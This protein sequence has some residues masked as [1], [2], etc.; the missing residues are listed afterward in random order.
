MADKYTEPRPTPRQGDASM[1]ALY[2]KAPPTFREL[3]A[4]AIDA[5]SNAGAA[6][7]GFGAG[8]G[9]KLADAEA[10]AE[11]K[12]AELHRRLDELDRYSGLAP[13]WLRYVLDGRR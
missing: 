3:L 5:A 9:R 7:S 2:S 12:L 13:T 11:A 4:A 8:A 1:E 6:K 10:D